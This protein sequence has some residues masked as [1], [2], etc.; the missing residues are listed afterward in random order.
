MS[1]FIRLGR[2]S[3]FVLGDFFGARDVPVAGDRR[4]PHDNRRRR[5]GPEEIDDPL[6]PTTVAEVA[7][8]MRRHR[9][10][11]HAAPRRRAMGERHHRRLV[12]RGRRR[13]V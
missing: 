13:P 7:L 8:G 4:A 9:Q 1:Y 5:T 11:L 3:P 10:E 2:H 12:S 6:V